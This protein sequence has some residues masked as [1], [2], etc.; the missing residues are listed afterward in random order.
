LKAAERR[1]RD[2]KA[3]HTADKG[4]GD[5]VEREVRKA[6]EE[7][8]GIDAID[9]T[10]SDGEAEE[11][12]AE[13]SKEGAKRISPQPTAIRPT[14]TPR[15]TP[16]PSQTVATRPAHKATTA[17]QKPISDAAMSSD[18]LNADWSCPVC[19]LLNPA[20]TLSCEA[21]AAPKPTQK[22]SK[23]G[24]YCEFCAAGPRDV[25]FWSC[26]ECGWVRKWG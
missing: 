12:K 2:D 15:S 20:Y 21:C 14:K 22:T 16:I 7:S 26:T 8:V 23:A 9:L 3:C 24:W 18:L 10:G 13:S 25:E 19:T 1:I 4:S 17:T 11:V 5:D 6:Q